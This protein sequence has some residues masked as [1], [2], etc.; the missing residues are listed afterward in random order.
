MKKHKYFKQFCEG[1][2]IKQGVMLICP[3][4]LIKI[5]STNNAYSYVIKESKN[6]CFKCQFHKNNEG[7]SLL[8]I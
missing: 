4:C 6:L 7:K 1:K 8:I 3:N 5:K 2:K